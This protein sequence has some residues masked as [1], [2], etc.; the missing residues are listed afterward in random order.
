[1]G[2]GRQEAEKQKS[3]ERERRAQT[4]REDEMDDQKERLPQLQ[5][6][7]GPP[8]GPQKSYEPASVGF[9][10]HLQADLTKVHSSGEQGCWAWVKEQ[11]TGDFATTRSG[12]WPAR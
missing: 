9:C 2:W 7:A 4:E 10:P 5:D 12:E 3:A 1:M 8:H 6:A 11:S